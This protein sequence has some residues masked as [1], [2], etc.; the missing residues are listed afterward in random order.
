MHDPGLN[1]DLGDTIDSLRDAIAR[2]SPPTR[3]RRAPPRSTAT[4]CSRTTCGRSS[5]TWACTA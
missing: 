4:T 5:A 1:F 3:S 2:T